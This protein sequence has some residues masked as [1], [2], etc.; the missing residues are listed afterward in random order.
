[1]ASKMAETP[2][3][4]FRGGKSLEKLPRS[5]QGHPI[6]FTRTLP[7]K[8]VESPRIKVSRMEIHKRVLL[9]PRLT[10]AGFASSNKGDRR[11]TRETEQG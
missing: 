4:V 8:I 7:K 5:R 2:S 1:M 11:A 9:F 10:L 6:I 3:F